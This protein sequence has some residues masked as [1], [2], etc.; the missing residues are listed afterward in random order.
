MA[1]TL[2]LVEDQLDTVRQGYTV[3]ELMDLVD[4]SETSIRKALKELIGQ[5]VAV[6]DENGNYRRPFY[7]TDPSE[8]EMDAT[9]REQ[10]ATSIPEDEVRPEHDEEEKPSAQQEELEKV[11]RDSLED[12]KKSATD[13]PA[14]KKY[15]PRR[16]N[17]DRP[18]RKNHK[19]GSELQ[20][21]PPADF[22]VWY[23]KTEASATNSGED[24][25]AYAW[26]TI[27]HTHSMFTG[28]NKIMAAW[29]Y[30]TN[31]EKFCPGCHEALTKKD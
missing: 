7:N 31:P 22:K 9:M 4:K 28:T 14:K 3:S 26:Y 19:T 20:V 13:K 5:G 11:L 10:M 15:A 27:C 16:E 30:S 25:V 24:A 2:Q 21:V 29:A 6:K 8:A 12:A 23:E 18:I 17:P 1:T